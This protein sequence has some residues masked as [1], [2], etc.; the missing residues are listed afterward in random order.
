MFSP[1]FAAAGIGKVPSARL[2]VSMRPGM[3]G[4]VVGGADEDR[5]WPAA[6]G[7][8]AAGL[9]AA[10]LEAAGLEAAGLAAGVPAEHAATA[11]LAAQ[12]AR[13]SAAGRCMFIG[14]PHSVHKPRCP[15]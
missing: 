7:L 1:T 11:R 15:P 9:D 4:P 2:T 5:P 6:A 10:G 14:S 8:D 3:G 13:A 12:A